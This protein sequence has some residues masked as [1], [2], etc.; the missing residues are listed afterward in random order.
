MSNDDLMQE[1]EALAAKMREK[2]PELR[3]YE[4]GVKASLETVAGPVRLR[5]AR[6][7][8]PLAERLRF[9]PLFV[10]ERVKR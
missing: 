4:K 2:F 6:R 8:I 1:A 3:Q 5:Q 10:V 7:G 9:P